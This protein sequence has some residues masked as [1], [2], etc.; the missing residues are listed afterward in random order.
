MEKKKKKTLHLSFTLNFW[1]FA[2][3]LHS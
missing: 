3:I 2:D 1:N